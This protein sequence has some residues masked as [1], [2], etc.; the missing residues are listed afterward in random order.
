MNEIWPLITQ[1]FNNREIAGAAWV[2]LILGLVS[3]KKD[4]RKSLLGVVRAI[5]DRR[6]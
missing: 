1:N 6:L 3:I 2:V 5:A 4:V